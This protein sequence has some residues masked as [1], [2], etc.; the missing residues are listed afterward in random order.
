MGKFA[1]ALR[2]YLATAK[3]RHDAIDYA[4][5][6]F[7]IAVTMAAAAALLRLLMR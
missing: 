7:A 4:R 2:Q 6:A 3:G 1:E 5:A